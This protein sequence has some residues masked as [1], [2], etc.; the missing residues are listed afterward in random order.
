MMMKV[1]FIMQGASYTSAR[2]YLFL[3]LDCYTKSTRLT[4]ETGCSFT[5]DCLIDKIKWFSKLISHTFCY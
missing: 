1:V 2:L 5:V 3:Q 4:P